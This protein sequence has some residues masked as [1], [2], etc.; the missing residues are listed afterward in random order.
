VTPVAGPNPGENTPCATWLASGNHDTAG[1]SALRRSGVHERLLRKAGGLT[2]PPLRAS[3]P[4]RAKL[5]LR[6]LPERIECGIG[7]QVRRGF[8]IGKQDEHRAGGRAIVAPGLQRDFAAPGGHADRVGV[9]HAGLALQPAPADAAD[10]GSHGL[11]HLLEDKRHTMV[12][13]VL[14]K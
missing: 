2:R 14:C 10:R 8:H 1:A 9:R 11:A 13:S 6:N 12:A 5:E 3:H 4:H 7:Q